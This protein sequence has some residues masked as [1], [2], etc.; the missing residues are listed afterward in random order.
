MVEDSDMVTRLGLGQG[1]DITAQKC[2]HFSS[3]AMC[4]S[5]GLTM[6]LPSY[7]GSVGMF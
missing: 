3:S 7:S 1:K 4:L 2:P 5:L 6:I